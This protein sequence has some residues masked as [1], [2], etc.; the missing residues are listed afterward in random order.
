M[1]EYQVIGE[2]LAV[3]TG[4]HNCGTNPSGP[5]ETLCGWEALIPMARV[6][7]LLEA[8]ATTGLREPDSPA[9]EAARTAYG[10]MATD[11]W[12]AV[13]DDLSFNRRLELLDRLWALG[14]RKIKREEL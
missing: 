6:E 5:H 11:L 3:Y 2:T 8:E 14:Y 12:H 9:E 10:R 7:D 1:P 13:G 4:Q